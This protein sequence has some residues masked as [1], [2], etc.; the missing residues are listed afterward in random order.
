MTT[1]TDD[2]NTHMAAYF[3]LLSSYSASGQAHTARLPGGV[4]HSAG[5]SHPLYNGF[6]QTSDLPEPVAGVV[7]EQ[8]NYFRN[9]QIPFTFW[10][11]AKE[12]YETI[13]TV[14]AQEGMECPGVFQV[15]VVAVEEALACANR[16]QLCDG[17]GDVRFISTQAELE[18]VTDVLIRVFFDA[19]KPV[20]E[21]VM[22][23]GRQ[24]LL[25]VNKAAGFSGHMRHCLARQG[26]VATGSATLFMTEGTQ[27]RKIAGFWNDAVVP[28]GRRKGTGLAMAVAR[29]Y[30]AA[31]AG[32]T[33]LHCTLMADA[34][35]RG[36]YDRLG[37]EP[38]AGL[39]PFMSQ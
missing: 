37:F 24:F 8:V 9:R 20:D 5:V 11:S 29:V 6:F 32:A 28:E 18:Q 13:R 22:S 15:C 33:H 26:A 30:E 38:V 19:Q 10:V 4:R 21:E 25:H 34:M 23:R 1:I 31:R 27:G 12:Q 36:Y 39:Y 35:A 7:K 2:L 3:A 14:L 16:V 17:A